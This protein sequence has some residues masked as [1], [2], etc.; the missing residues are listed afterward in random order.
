MVGRERA[1]VLSAEAAILISEGKHEE[2]LVKINESISC[3]PINQCSWMMKC[4]CLQALGN[5]E[6]TK[7]AIEKALTIVVDDEC[8]LLLKYMLSIV[9]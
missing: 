9:K 2:A 3:N 7:T 4:I 5:R 6:E 1:S 8:R